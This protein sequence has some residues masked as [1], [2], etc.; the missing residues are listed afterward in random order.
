MSKED[1]LVKHVEE[2][3]KECEIELPYDEY[4]D[5]VNELKEVVET[6]LETLKKK[7]E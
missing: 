7:D 1:E 3:L 5:V 6:R 2:F 4:M